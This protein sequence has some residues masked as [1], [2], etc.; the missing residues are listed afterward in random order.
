MVDQISVDGE[1]LAEIKKNA[2]TIQEVEEVMKKTKK[3]STKKKG[4]K[5]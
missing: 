1:L 5:K 2:S 3:K 4:A